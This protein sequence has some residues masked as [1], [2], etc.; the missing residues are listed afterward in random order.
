EQ[1]IAHGQLV[2]GDARHLLISVWATTQAYANAGAHLRTEKRTRRDEELEV[3]VAHI[4]RLVLR[5][6][7]TS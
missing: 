6:V 7:L 4:S 5:G 1:W 3:A 2:A